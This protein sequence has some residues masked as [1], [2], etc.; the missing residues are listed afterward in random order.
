MTAPS[1]QRQSSAAREGVDEFAAVIAGGAGMRHALHMARRIATTPLRTLLLNGE[2]GTGKE[3]V[4]RCIH[5]GGNHANAPFV[6]INCASIPAPLLEV[7]LF[8]SAPSRSEAARKLG[9][10]ELAD[11]GT[12]FLD[13]VGEM[14]VALQDRLLQTPEEYSIP[15]FSSGNEPT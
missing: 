4:A 1:V 14:P 11:R 7:E 5:N 2:A 8:G 9:V 6:S 3:L 15:R 12:L 13:E 10:L